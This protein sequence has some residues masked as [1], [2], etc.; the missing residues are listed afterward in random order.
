MCSQRIRSDYKIYK[1]ILQHLITKKKVN[2]QH[3]YILP[4]ETFQRNRKKKNLFL[5]P[6]I[7]HFF[8]KNFFHCAVQRGKKSLHNNNTHPE[9]CQR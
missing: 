1:T 3:F 9:N 7:R 4:L 5:D 2:F 6:S 8:S